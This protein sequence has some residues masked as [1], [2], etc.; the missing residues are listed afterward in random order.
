MRILIFFIILVSLEFNYSVQLF[1]TEKNSSEKL[2]ADGGDIWMIKD[3]NGPNGFSARK[4]ETVNIED[5]LRAVHG[6]EVEYVEPSKEDKN[7]VPNVEKSGQILF[8]QDI[9]IKGDGKRLRKCKG[10][11]M[12][13][14]DFAHRMRR[15]DRRWMI[16]G[17]KP[18]LEHVFR[19]LID[20]HAMLTL[21]TDDGDEVARFHF[22][23]QGL[24][25][26][27]KESGN[28]IV[29]QEDLS[30]K[31]DTTSLK[32]FRGQYI[33][34][35]FNPPLHTRKMTI[36]EVK[37]VAH[38]V[39][40]G[41][42]WGGE[43]GFKCHHFV[44]SL[45]QALVEEQDKNVLLDYWKWPESLRLLDERINRLDGTFAFNDS[46]PLIYPSSNSST[47]VEKQGIQ[48]TK[49][50]RKFFEFS[51]LCQLQNGETLPFPYNLQCTPN[52]KY[53]TIA[54]SKNWKGLRAQ[55]PTSTINLQIRKPLKINP[56]M[57]IKRQLSNPLLPISNP[58]FLKI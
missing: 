11:K 30:E 40:G 28:V 49:D 52:L 41:R 13:I 15:I 6:I 42:P 29:D 51:K 20:G 3:F 45:A 44:Y 27:R 39:I 19:V 22:N 8:K 34:N 32:R 37:R 26:F 48:P 55:R 21:L 12:Y 38:D 1:S 54:Y 10:E 16:T 53:S 58:Q 31:I 4:H 57:P 47:E 43:D 7:F 23:R 2:K 24:N 14:W 56:T 36:E 18:K 5:V 9:D 33:K 35:G 17:E 46:V 25:L 50:K